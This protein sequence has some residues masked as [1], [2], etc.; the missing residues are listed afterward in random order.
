MPY[1]RFLAVLL[2][3]FSALTTLT[4]RSQEA[5][6][7]ASQPKAGS[8]WARV[9]A[10]PARTRIHISKD[11]GSTTCRVFA[12]TDDT[13]T[14]EAGLGKAGHVIQR[15]EIRTIK[16]THYGRSAL[17]GAGIGGGIGA[18]SGA[19]AGRNPPCQP[20]NFC[21]NIL[22]PGAVAAVFGV[23]GAV[24]GSIAG[25]VTDMTRGSSIYTRP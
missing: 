20:N 7:P 5:P 13:L 8:N 1:R 9:K 23:S 24:V 19:I 15:P 25:G 14:C 17:V 3:S 22:G 21:F 11:H 10:L 2:L 12:V 4:A 18:I 16:L 6:A